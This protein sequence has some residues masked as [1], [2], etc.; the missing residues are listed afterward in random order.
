VR[1][2]VAAA[3][4]AGLASTP[5]VAAQEATPPTT[6]P[7]VLEAATTYLETLYAFDFETLATLLAPDATFYDPTAAPLTG[8]DTRYAGRDQIVAEFS[9]AAAKA[10]NGGY[11][12]ERQFVSGELA[13]F[14]LT[15]SSELDGNAFGVPGEWVPVRVAGIT[16]IR[17]VDGLVTEHLDH[18]DYE[19]M[20]RQIEEFVAARA[21]GDGR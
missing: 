14:T 3:L 10:R 16:V 21:P 9:G 15:Y 5:P 7:T 6:P 11:E 12:I 13:V 17:V 2:L 20:L 4:L 8:S 18:V 19:S 1:R